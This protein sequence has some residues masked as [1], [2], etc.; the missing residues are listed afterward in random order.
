MTGQV[1]IRFAEEVKADGHRFAVVAILSIV[2]RDDR[3]AWAEHSPRDVAR[4][5]AISH[6]ANFLVLDPTPTFQALLSGGRVKE[7]VNAC[8]SHW[9]AAAHAWAAAALGRFLEDQGWIP[10]P[11]GVADDNVD[12][13]PFPVP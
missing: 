4:L 5:E 6:R 7:F 1:L 3:G 13:Q 10:R 9:T 11:S 8:D 12:P 2:E